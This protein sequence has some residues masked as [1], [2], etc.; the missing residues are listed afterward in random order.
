MIKNIVLHIN[1]ITMYIEEK[2]K[3]KKGEMLLC[4]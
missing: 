1:E 2:E 4:V 3:A